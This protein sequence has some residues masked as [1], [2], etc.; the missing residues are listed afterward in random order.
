MRCMRC[1]S[2]EPKE[3]DLDS[4]IREEMQ[5]LAN[6]V[7]TLFGAA[8]LVLSLVAPIRVWCVEGV[9]DPALRTRVE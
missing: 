1:C 9:R 7:G 3:G 2:D 4:V 5:S 8:S 6:A